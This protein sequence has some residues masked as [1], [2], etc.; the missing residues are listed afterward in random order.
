[1]TQNLMGETHN[2]KGAKEREGK[3]PTKGCATQRVKSLG[4]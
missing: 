2:R 3:L 1:M 4:A